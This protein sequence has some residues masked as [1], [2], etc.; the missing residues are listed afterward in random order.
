MGIICSNEMEIPLNKE[1]VDVILLYDVLHRGYFPE[2][3]SRK[4]ILNNIYK[5][6][7]KNGFISVYLTHLRQ[8]G[9]TLKKVI[10][11]I[12]NVGFVY[13]GESRRKLVHDNNLVRGQ[14]FAFKKQKGNKEFYKAVML[15]VKVYE[16]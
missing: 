6:L 11:E 13:S 14:I 7:C 15:M 10:A 1:S 9:M 3:E 8:F 2:I 4:K 16:T 12:E 5:I